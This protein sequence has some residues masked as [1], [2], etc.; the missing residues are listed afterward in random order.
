MGTQ[1]SKIEYSIAHQ[2]AKIGETA[3]FRNPTAKHGL[4][5]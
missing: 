3:V 5:D 4:M 2:P 1:L